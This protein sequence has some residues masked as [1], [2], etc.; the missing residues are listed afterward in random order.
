[1]L[2]LRG[3][4]PRAVGIIGVAVREPGALHCAVGTLKMGCAVLAWKREREKFSE[5]TR[6]S[7]EFPGG[8]STVLKNHHFTEGFLWTALGL[9]PSLSLC[10]TLFSVILELQDSSIGGK[11]MQIA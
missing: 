10:G 2:I 7:Q 3:D 4:G 8:G 11:L 1:M 6:T 5:A 9:A